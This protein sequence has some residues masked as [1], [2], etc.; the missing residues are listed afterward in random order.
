M[1]AAV[2]HRGKGLVVEEIPT[3]EPAPD[4]VLLKIANTGFCGSDHSLLETDGLPEGIILGHEVSGVVIKAGSRV[5]DVQEGAKVIVRP[6]FCGICPGC[7]IGRTQLCSSNRRSI[8][9]GDLPGGFA[10]YVLVYPGMLIPVPDNVDSKNAALAEMCAVSLHGIDISGRRGGSVLVIGGGAIGLS[11][12]KLLRL[13]GYEPIV[14]SEPVAEKRALAKEFGAEY[15][16]DPISENIQ[17]RCF[18]INSGNGFDTIFEC[19]GRPETLLSAMDM[20][21][22]GGMV[23]MISVVYRTIE[24][25]PATMMFK[26]VQL[27]ASYGNTHAENAECLRWMSEGKLDVR[28]LI[29][30][31]ITL[32]QLPSVYRSRIHTGKAV[33][34]MLEIGDPF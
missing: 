27:T 34:V 32:S 7:R 14:V 22:P 11:M 33:K 13:L 12:V 2:Y 30:D 4:Q 21:A 25:N 16:I 5:K 6:T 8:G 28:P 29:S 26:E 18:E 19:S 23:C 15:T 17:Q 24:I 10:E 3:P 9:I 20:S 1:K 31:E